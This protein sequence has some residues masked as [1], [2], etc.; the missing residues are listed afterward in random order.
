LQLQGVH[1]GGHSQSPEE[2]LFAPAAISSFAPLSKH[3]SDG[4]HQAQYAVIKIPSFATEVKE[5]F[6]NEF[7]PPLSSHSTF[8]SCIQALF[9][10]LLL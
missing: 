3:H 8:E 1:I 5:L 7:L 10:A 6:S 9:S 2:E 4:A